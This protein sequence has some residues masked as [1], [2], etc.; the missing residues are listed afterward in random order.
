MQTIDRRQELLAAAIDHAARS[1]LGDLSL[2]GLAAELGTSHRMLIH[3]FGS[4][5]GLW[6]AIVREV[7]QRQIAAMAD[8]DVDASAALGDVL[9]VRWRAIADPALWPSERLF[10]EVYARALHEAPGTEGFLDEVVE[11]WLEPAADLAVTLG[12]PR[13]DALAFARLTVAVTRGLLL[14]VLATGERAGPD[15]AMEVFVQT[16]EAW[17]ATAS[18]DR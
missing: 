13:A 4:K 8:L 18:V 17:I 1:G 2:R 7:E 14:D 3:H 5:E 9:R 12:V 11:A 16:V 15:A 6:T 10:F